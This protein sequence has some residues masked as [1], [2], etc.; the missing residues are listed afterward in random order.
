MSDRC[1]TPHA[2]QKAKPPGTCRNVEAENQNGGAVRCGE[3][4]G[5][6]TANAIWCDQATGL[7]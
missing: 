6:R 1:L 7:T 4:F 2:E 5:G 3:G